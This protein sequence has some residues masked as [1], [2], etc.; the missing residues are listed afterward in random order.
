[1]PFYDFHCPSCDRIYEKKMSVAESE[2]PQFCEE[3][4]KELVQKI[5]APGL[6]FIG[7]WFT[8]NKEY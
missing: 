3:D 7:K 8:N 6:S 1:M 2:Q 5:G 4:G